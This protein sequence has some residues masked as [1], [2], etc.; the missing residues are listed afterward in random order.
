MADETA[1]R[2]AGSPDRGGHPEGGRSE[3]APLQSRARFLQNW[4]WLSVTQINGGLCERGGAQR[5]I[6][7]E[8]HAAVA[9]EWETRRTRDLSLLEV[10]DFLRSCHKRAPFLFFNGNTFAEIGRA[11]TN[12][13]LRDLPFHRRKEAASAAAHFITG[14][15]DRELMIQMMNE[16]CEASDFKAGD[17]VKTLRGSMRGKIIRV[18]KDGRVVWRADSGA[19]L[20]ALPESLLK[21]DKKQ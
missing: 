7:S 5:G 9:E 17:E 20:T 18:L 16:M 3:P 21:L 12:A 13:L 4:D 6:N 8:T 1:N 19:E 11:L 14:V 2:P 10:F 15:L